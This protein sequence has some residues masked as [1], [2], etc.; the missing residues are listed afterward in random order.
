[1]ILRPFETPDEV[2]HREACERIAAGVMALLIH[3]TT[4]ADAISLAGYIVAASIVRRAASS[5]PAIATNEV[6]GLVS[7]SIASAL[8]LIYHQPGH[9]VRLIVA[10]PAAVDES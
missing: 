6:H 5:S 7:E 4:P 3:I 1:M 2:K 9:L 8:D 10:P